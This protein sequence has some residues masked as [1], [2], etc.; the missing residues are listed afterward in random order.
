MAEASV[1]LVKTRVAANARKAFLDLERTK[2]IRDLT[3]RLI[4]QVAAATSPQLEAEM[5]QSEL[6][7]RAAYREL[8][9]I[10]EGR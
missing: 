2:K 5:F 3:R 8:R 9:R 6:D 7:Y 10:M 1:N 4:S